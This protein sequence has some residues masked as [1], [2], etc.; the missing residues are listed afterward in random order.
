MKNH[1][2]S[3]R[4]GQ[5]LASC[6]LLSLSFATAAHAQDTTSDKAKKADQ[7]KQI[8]EVVVTG[9]RIRQNPLEAKAPVQVMSAEDIDQSGVVGIADF[10]QRLPI[11]GSAI[12]RTNNSSGNLGF[13]PDGSGI[14]AGASEVDLRYL[15]SKRVLVL[16]DGKRWVRGSSASGVSGAVD[17]NTIPT[18][19]IKSIEV[20]QDGASTIYGSDAIA[21]VVNIKTSD[22]YDGIHGSAYYGLYG[23][24]DG[25]TQE[26]DVSFGAKADKARMFLDVS[27]AKQGGISAG[28]RDISAYPIP[29]QTFGASSGTPQGRFLFTD[30]RNGET[31]NL[32]I[33][34]GVGGVPS[35]DY[36]DPTGGDFHNF[37]LADRFN[38]QPYNYLSTP[39]ERVNVFAKAEYD[40]TDTIT[41]RVLAAFNNRQSTSRAA[42][43]PLFFGPDG[44]GG[45]W[46][47][48]VSIS[49]NNP[50][51]PFGITLDSSNLI[52]IG[53]R[54]IEAGPR[55]FEQNVNTWYIANTIDGSFNAGGKDWYWDVNA[56]WS[57]NNASQIKHGAFNARKLFDALGDPAACSAIPGCV[58]FNLFGGQG[59]DGNGSITKAMLDYVTFAQKDVSQQKLLDL[60]ANLSGSV[61]DLPAG[62]LGVAVGWEYREEQGSFTPD[63]IVSSGETA[64]VPASPT[65]GKIH[66][67]EIYGETNVPL[68]SDVSGAKLLALD[69]AF[70]WSDYSTSGS[71]TVFKVGGVWQVNDDLTFRGNWS[72][73][74][75]APNI[76]E[77]FN[78]G[79]RFDAGITDPCDS[80][81][82]VVPDNC[83]TFGLPADYNQPNP[84][85][86]VTTGGNRN[87]KPEQ[88]KTWTAGL[89]YSPKGLADSMGVDLITFEANYYNIKINDA[90]QAP[91][92]ADVLNRCVDTL[93]PTA[94]GAITRSSTGTVTRID[95]IL[96]NIA[97]I[98]TSGLDWSIALN[99]T[100]ADWGQMR[101]KWVNSHLFKYEQTTPTADGFQV[102]DLAGEELGSPTRAY[103]KWKSSLLVDWTL[104][105]WSAGATFRYIDTVWEDC[106]GTV[107]DFG[108]TN[109]CTTPT[110]NKLKGR[111]Y[112][113]LQVTYRPT[114]LNDKVGITFGVQNLLK[115]A[116]PICYSCDLNSMDG[117]IYPVP[118][119]FFYGRISFTL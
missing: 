72:E 39:N 31:M 75:R 35:Y 49:A 33:N 66:S 69:A 27:Y 87:L 116:T 84:Q 118:G 81:D 26:Y 94:C 64:G 62:P 60:T 68:L 88:A 85:I 77:L 46:M 3:N 63:A 42:P 112:T 53:R 107:A 17:L 22:N 74:F 70:R 41:Y 56:V 101:F 110:R 105:E 28:D 15:T 23:Q 92:A 45:H 13:P 20:L 83:A 99:T 104:D 44:G 6:A 82:G 30:P 86:S 16:V 25:K 108:F 93:D 4:K 54:P 59:A 19:A 90:I 111:L 76:G 79:S 97:S 14:G 37:A 114:D 48:N 58:P 10:L 43:E 67:K 106:T 109:Q 119:R 71:N 65:A 55:V 12:N 89:T 1:L 11:A 102:Q 36:A 38:Y 5:L 80:S 47:E 100:P 29:G 61:A 18:G 40:L 98:K 7:P 51:N 24:G 34:D 91:D 50:Y 8:E 32:T 95:G 52:F 113:D 115:T 73:G 9:S 96:Q 117:T 2:A 57:Q 78:S 21:G 103:V